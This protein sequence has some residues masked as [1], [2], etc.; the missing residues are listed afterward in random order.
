[1][2][3]TD[4]LVVGGGLVGNALAYY[5]ARAGVDVL[6][7]DRD[8]VNNAASG[9]NAGSLHVQLTSSY[10]DKEAPAD[11]ERAV[12][13]M[14]S[15]L[16]QSIATWRELSRE[17]D[18]DVELNVGGG[19][20]VAET[21][22][23]MRGLERKAAI[24]RR[25]G[26]E[27]ELLGVNEVRAI[28]P[29]LGPSI[30]GAEFCPLEG[31]VNPLPATPALARGAVRAGARIARH[32]TLTSFR[33]ESDAIVAETDRGD[34]RC[35]R[36]VCATGAWTDAILNRAGARLPGVSMPQHMNV[37][38]PVEHFMDHLVQ[39]AGGRLTLKQ[40]ADGHVIIGGGRP[41]EL[42][43]ATGFVR[44]LRTSIEG[45]VAIAL[46]VVPRLGHLRIVRTW[47]GIGFMTDGPPVLGPV[48]GT[49]GLYV[50]VPAGPGC[51]SGPFSARL[52]A[53]HLMGK[54]PALD[55]AP[56]T[57]ERFAGI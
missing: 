55:L 1:M 21:D 32:R 18:C 35:Q 50:A 31:K 40:G 48:P 37:S 34:I 14:I 47:A 30:I 26:L 53:D 2:E 56:F 54:P 51:T 38:E 23:E 33:R 8:D 7:I 46:H 28:A 9:R 6:L 39:H 43:P 41:A 13:A 44:V 17:L 29:Y 27:V 19:L 49:E 4:V 11:A 22:D 57:I 20:M 25:V 5:L 45:N 52:L 16:V 10:L 15:V 42:D 24:E 36:M 3:R 12:E